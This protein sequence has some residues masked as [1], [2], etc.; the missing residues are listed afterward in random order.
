MKLKES[1][2]DAEPMDHRQ[3]RYNQ[4]SLV[5]FAT[6]RLELKLTSA[7][8]KEHTITHGY[9]IFGI[10]RWSMSKLRDEQSMY[11]RRNCFSLNF[12]DTYVI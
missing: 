10:L 1:A 8:I 3:S 7:A 12:I 6:D 9:I 11:Y 2:E 5:I 4:S